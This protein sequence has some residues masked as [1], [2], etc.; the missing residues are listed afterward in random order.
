VPL[1]IK[2]AASQ[3]ASLQRW[4][5]SA[6]NELVSVEP[7]GYLTFG[8]GTNQRIYSQ[9]Q[10]L[11]IDNDGTNKQIY[12]RTD[13]GGAMQTRCTIGPSGSADISLNYAVAI[14]WGNNYIRR[15]GSNPNVLELDGYHG[16]DILHS[17][18]TEGQRYLKFYLHYSDGIGFVDGNN[19]NRMA[20]P[21]DGSRITFSTDV[22]VSD[23][24]AFTV[25]DG[26]I[27]S[28]FG[29]LGKSENLLLDSD[30]FTTANWTS[31][32]E[33]Y[34]YSGVIGPDGQTRYA[35]RGNGG[36]WRCYQDVTV[37]QGATYTASVW[38]YLMNAYNP[39]LSLHD[40]TDDTQIAFAYGSGRNQWKRVV[41]TA[42]A[43]STTLRFS[44]G[45]L[46]NGAYAFFGWAQLVAGDAPRVYTQ[47]RSSA[48]AAGYG[49]HLRTKT[50]ADALKLDYAND[51]VSVDADFVVPVRSDS[52][53]GSAGTAG[54]IIFNTTDGQLNVD[55]GTNWTL[56]DGTTT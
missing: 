15:S 19:V 22:Q 6:G 45:N 41:V 16:T 2:G 53:R 51:K 18:T 47:T 25:A 4:E 9:D 43:T 21:S 56:P 36:T 46:T 49:V 33:T 35:H 24:W 48:Q 38:F 31:S 50:K 54:R 28:V 14:Q 32:N 13:W 7:E 11:Y 29:G 40:G 3:S 30:D 55:D 26:Q 10:Q 23:G 39:K 8:E 12:L 17:V 27:N 37:T 5:D 44:L 42:T 34:P 52:D 1:T 20:M